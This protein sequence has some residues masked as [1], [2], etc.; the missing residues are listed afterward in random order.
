MK[1]AIIT[2]T[3]G[4]ADLRKCVESVLNQSYTNICHYI[5]VDGGE[6][7]DS[8][9]TVL[10]DLLPCDRI[11]I[12]NLPVNTGRNGYY[13]HR[14]YAAIPFLIDCD[15]LIYLDDD[16][17]IDSD[18]LKDCLSLL[19]KYKLDW[20]YSLRKIFDKN[21]NYLCDDNCE[22]LGI[23]GA[24]CNHQ[25]MIDTNCYFLTVSIARE[26]SKI[27]MAKGYCDDAPEPDKLLARYLI[28]NY[29]NCLTTGHYTLN[30]KLGSS[31]DTAIAN[32]FLDG[33]KASHQTFKK[34]PW[35]DIRFY[36]YDD[37]KQQRRIVSYSESK[38]NM[39]SEWKLPDKK[40]AKR[41]ADEYLQKTEG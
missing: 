22:S 27:W 30:Y 40:K 33:N 13:G 10:H 39:T 25:S 15:Y 36:Q 6:Y 3:T 17:W 5:V 1:I 26:V 35:N 23:W 32:Y 29:P 16:N 38:Q 7:L 28:F 41:T 12:I 37:F 8:V 2:P 9:K 19:N 31:D 14:I 11:R 24:W 20:C 18:H 4:R 21:S 34:F